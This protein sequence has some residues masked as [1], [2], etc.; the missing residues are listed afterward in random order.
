M[1]ELNR[2][3]RRISEELRSLQEELQRAGLVVTPEMAR[4]RPWE[5]ARQMSALYHRLQALIALH[6][7]TPALAPYRREPQRART[8]SPR[9]D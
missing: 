9:P 5:L 2:S 7:G 1:D 8:E 4:V 6:R 3:I